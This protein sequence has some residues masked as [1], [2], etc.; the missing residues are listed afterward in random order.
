MA[1]LIAIVSSNVVTAGVSPFFIGPFI[2]P[3]GTFIIGATFI[4]R[5]FVQNFVGRRK[6]Y[7][8]ILIAMI[9]SALTSYLLGDT[10]WIV[11]ASIITFAVSETTDTEIYS[12]LKLPFH[13][14]VAYSG[15][16]GGILDSIIFVIIGLSPLGA[17]ILPWNAVFLAIVGQIIVK[18]LVQIV[19]AI[20]VKRIFFRQG[21]VV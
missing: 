17:N 21:K 11:F 7:L 19:A 12:R 8:L 2:I 10:L 5:D 1:Y 4:F 15:I 20:V 14:R 18:T 6:T 3:A 16:V 9:L 13:L